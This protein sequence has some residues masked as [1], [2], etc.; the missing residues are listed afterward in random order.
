MRGERVCVPERCRAPQNGDT[1][2]HLASASGHTKVVVKLLNAKA[3]IEVKN[4]VRGRG[5]VMDAEREGSRGSCHLYSFEKSR[6]PVL[7]FAKLEK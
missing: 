6:V 2:L 1:P 3:T 7:H 4:K 5:G